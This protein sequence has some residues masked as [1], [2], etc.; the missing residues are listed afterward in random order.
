MACERDNVLGRFSPRMS[1]TGRCARGRYDGRTAGELDGSGAN[2]GP[3]DGLPRLAA[4][5]AS[6][7][8]AARPGVVGRGGEKEIVWVLKCKASSFS[9]LLV[10]SPSRS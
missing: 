6:G 2:I 9:F 10:A 4:D 3:V 8:G 7:H 5:G 1:A